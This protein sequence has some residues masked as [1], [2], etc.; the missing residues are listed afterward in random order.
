MEY[1]KCFVD[2]LEFLKY[3]FC[4]CENKSYI[5]ATIMT[6]YANIFC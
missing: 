5:V 4:V 3:G 1:L 6:K 2:S